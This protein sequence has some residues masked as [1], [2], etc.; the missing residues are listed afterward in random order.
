[1]FVT[2]CHRSGTSLM[3]AVLAELLSQLRPDAAVQ[4]LALRSDLPN[5]LDNPLGFFESPQL[6]LLNDELLGLAGCAWDRPP[7]LE[8]DWASLMPLARLENARAEFRLQALDRHWVDKDPRLALTFRA[9]THILL[10]RPPLVVML[11]DPAEV[12]ASLYSRNG[13]GWQLDRGLVLWYLYNHHLASVVQPGDLLL[14]YG[15]LLSPDAQSR[16]AVADA[17]AVWLQGQSFDAVSAHQCSTVLNHMVKPD[18]QRSAA[19]LGSVPPHSQAS[20]PLL[21]L[22]STAYRQVAVASGDAE[23]RFVTCFQDLPQVVLQAFNSHDWLGLGP[24]AHS[25][26]SQLQNALV[27]QQANRQ[28]LEQSFSTHL[29]EH[30]ALIRAQQEQLIS[31]QQSLISLQQSLSWR[32]TAPLRRLTARLRSSR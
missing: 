15:Q 14:S 18:L 1:M 22:C 7:L 29:E 9:W 4:P 5:N 28:Q 10:R 24:S 20:E 16:D 8:V 12:A 6:R 31:L 21:A 32:C 17:L 25:Q 30:R 19:A 13:A 23:S 26:I 3:A 2:G 11:R 27:E